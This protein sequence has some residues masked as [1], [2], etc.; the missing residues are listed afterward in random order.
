MAEDRGIGLNV[1]DAG[2]CEHGRIVREWNVHIAD[3]IPVAGFTIERDAKVSVG[4]KM[5]VAHF[6]PDRTN[7]LP[8]VDAVS[9]AAVEIEA[10]R[11][12]AF[13]V[14]I[15]E[16]HVINDASMSRSRKDRSA[17]G[18]CRK[19]GRGFPDVQMNAPKLKPRN[20]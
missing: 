11:A 18:E 8:C 20:G 14:A 16:L 12:R 19:R 5:I 17:S 7:G 10:R 9:L 15:A 1:I 4:R 3:G 13:D 2:A 6:K